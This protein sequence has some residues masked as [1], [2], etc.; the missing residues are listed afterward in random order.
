MSVKG[1]A[2]GQCSAHV[3]HCHHGHET[4]P[5]TSKEKPGRRRVLPGLVHVCSLLPSI[6]RDSAPRLLSPPIV[7]SHQPIN[8]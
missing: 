1:T 4:H 3:G 8:I 5:D 2:R 6:C 7:M